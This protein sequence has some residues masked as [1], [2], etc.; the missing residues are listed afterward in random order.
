MDTAADA[1]GRPEEPEAA[2]PPSI[3]VPSIPTR[4][5]AARPP[6]PVPS[7]A[8][9][10]DTGSTDDGEGRG[11]TSE[12]PATGRAPPARRTALLTAPAPRTGAVSGSSSPVVGPDQPP[13][14]PGPSDDPLDHDPFGM[15]FP[16]G[17]AAK[18]GWYVYLLVPPG[19]G[20]PFYVGRGR[21]DR[22]FQHVRAA[23]PGGSQL[24]EQ[25]GGPVDGDHQEPG[26]RPGRPDPRPGK[27]PALDRIRQVEA[28][29][30]P[31]PGGDPAVRTECG[32]GPAGHG[33][34]VRCARAPVRRQAGK[35]AP[36]GGRPRDPAGQAG[37]VQAG[38]P[39]RPV[40]GRAEGDRH[41]LRQGPPRVA[42][43]TAVDRSAFDPLAPV[44]GDRG[45]RARGGRLPHR[46]VGGDPPPGPTGP[47]GPSGND[48]LHL[49]AVVH[50]ERGTSSS[51]PATWG[52]ASPATWA[53]APVPPPPPVPTWPSGRSNQVAYVWCGPHGIDRAG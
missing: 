20:L 18:L 23:R 3:G 34:R 8:V 44:G 29:G 37:Q 45:R 15:A 22:C 5:V 46:G 39:G 10:A 16:P 43:R 38:S 51:S 2:G 4:A 33:G 40:A 9:P 28:D 47:V 41:R 53:P 35:S 13:R 50:R 25:G 14:G 11:A 21:G 48:P 52:G 27:F 17:V 24:G 30:G 26:N 12:D 7:V 42:D 1:E 49:P 36:G 6:V 31:G 32:R 19:S